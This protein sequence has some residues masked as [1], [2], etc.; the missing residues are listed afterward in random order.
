MI[1]DGILPTS[2]QTP[3]QLGLKVDD[4]DSYLLH[5]QPIRKVSMSWSHR[6]WTITLKLL[7]IF[8]GVGE[9]GDIKFYWDIVILFA[10]QSNKPELFY[11]TQNYLWDLIR[12]WCSGRWAFGIITI[13]FTVS[14]GLLQWLT[15]LWKSIYSSDYWF[16]TKDTT[17][18]SQMEEIH[19]QGM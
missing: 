10:C 18:N 3:D 12:Y 19:G 2:M 4:A 16:L 15:E 11:F 8:S 17:W 5:H 7:T 13:P 9:E 14:V 1:N 6:L